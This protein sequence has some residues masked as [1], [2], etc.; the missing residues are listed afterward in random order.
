[1]PEKNIVIEAFTELAPSY[2]ET[3]DRELR[4]FWGIGYHEF[5]DRLAGMTPTS[6][7]DIVLDVATGTGVMPSKIVGRLGGTGQV[8]GLDITSAM[9]KHARENMQTLGCGPSVRFICG[10]AMEM[11][12]AKGVFD[13]VICG[14]GMHHMEARP[15]LS[16]MARV[17]KKGGRLVM[18]DVGAST[19]WRSFV[20]KLFLQ[21]LLIRYGLTHKGA[22]AEAEKAAF[23]NIYTPAE[24]QR[25][26]ASYG[27]SSIEIT[28]F[29]AVRPWY[30]SA[31]IIRAT[32]G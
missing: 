18:A 14:L 28:E 31:L 13:V 8:V 7:G 17:L 2:E 19:F 22:R 30:P 6:E 4:Q 25:L 27:F 24:W 16:E 15:L 20:G 29:K 12:L 23:S 9:L 21:V 10:S 11:P 26:L 5:I 3:V 32:I 1:M